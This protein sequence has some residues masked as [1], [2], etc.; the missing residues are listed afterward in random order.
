[1]FLNAF[2]PLGLPSL[3][4]HGLKMLFQSHQKSIKTMINILIQ[5]LIVFFGLWVD[6]GGQVGPK[7]FEKIVHQSIQEAIDC[8]NDFG[9]DL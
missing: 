1:M 8:V 4:P 3:K 5:F 7:I 9:I 2:W 6:F